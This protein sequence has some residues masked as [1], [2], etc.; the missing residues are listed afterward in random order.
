M[1]TVCRCLEIRDE[2]SNYLQTILFDE[3]V[4]LGF[5]PFQNHCWLLRS[6]TAEY[7][8]YYCEYNCYDFIFCN[9]K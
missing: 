8:E 6:S 9:L 1:S 3:G 5:Y 2:K 4:V 7:Y